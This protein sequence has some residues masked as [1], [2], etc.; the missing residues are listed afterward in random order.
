LADAPGSR[1][2]TRGGTAL[3]VVVSEAI[4]LMVLKQDFFRTFIADRPLA[5]SAASVS[6]LVARRATAGPPEHP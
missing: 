6:A 1:C 2:A 3:C 5:D 4:C